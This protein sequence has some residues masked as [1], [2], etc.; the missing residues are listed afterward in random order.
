MAG[1][2][3]F[4]GIPISSI[5]PVMIEDIR[6]SPIALNPVARERAVQG[7]AEFVRMRDGSRT[8][9]ITFALLEDDPVV[10]AAHLEH[11]RTWAKRDKEYP[12]MIYTV[13]GKYLTAVCTGFPEPS[14]RQWWES[15]L[16]ITFTCFDNP[17]WTSLAERSVP[18][19]TAFVALGDA[20]PLMR[21]EHIQTAASA[22]TYSL[23][24]RTM[25]FSQVPSGNLVI[26]LNRQT[27]AVDALS[28]MSTYTFTSRFLIPRTGTQTIT[29]TGTVKFRERWV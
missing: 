11:L 6:V 10:R 28:I 9:S 8:V 2:I 26:D 21:I 14:I 13:P 1:M 18:C 19:G 29:G 24:G 23:D 20:P 15:K 3:T 4:N 16:R 22:L 7:G 17:Y 25:T 12:L 5:A 27:A